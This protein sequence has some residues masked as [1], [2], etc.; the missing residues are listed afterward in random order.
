MNLEKPGIFA[1]NDSIDGAGLAA[2]VRK[3]EKLG[4]STFFSPE[5]FG[6]DPFTVVSHLLSL[7]DQIVLGTAI[8]NVWKRDA[9]TTIGAART[10]A[11]LFPGRFILGIGASHGPMMQ[12][13]GIDYSKPVVFMRDYIARMKS[14]PYT[15]PRPNAEPPIL[16]AA[17]LPKML[18]LSG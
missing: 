2:L 18:E 8:A 1:I 9:V 14:A 15:A 12:Q 17:L 10:L 3:I 11:E 4:Y 6:R 13:L 16:I 5:A 7:T